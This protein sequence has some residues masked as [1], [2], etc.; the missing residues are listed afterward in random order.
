MAI[1]NT[2]KS[3]FI[4]KQGIIPNPA[5]IQRGLKEV[6]QLIFAAPKIEKNPP[7]APLIFVSN[8]IPGITKRSFGVSA[9]NFFEKGTRAVNITLVIT[10]EILK[11]FKRTL[12]KE[13]LDK[14][15]NFLEGGEHFTLNSLD[16]E[17]ISLEDVQLLVES[18]I[19]AE[20][21]TD[22]DSSLKISHVGKDVSILIQNYL[23]DQRLKDDLEAVWNFLEKQGRVDEKISNTMLWSPEAR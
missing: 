22:N 2:Q 18:T 15:L 19:L 1:L 13:L 17:K 23:R 21:S 3:I 11:R 16:F 6:Y 8:E 4:Q 7:F 12:F 5:I 14:G 10:P 20:G 9:D